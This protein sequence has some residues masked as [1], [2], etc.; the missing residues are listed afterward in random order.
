MNMYF[1]AASGKVKNIYSNVEKLLLSHI[2]N[3]SEA[4]NSEAF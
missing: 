1:C 4:Y 3:N 2:K